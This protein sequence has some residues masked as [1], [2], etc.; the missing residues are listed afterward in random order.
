MRIQEVAVRGPIVKCFHNKV[1]QEKTGNHS[2][3]VNCIFLI[4]NKQPF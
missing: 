2:H 4:N 3:S 1:A